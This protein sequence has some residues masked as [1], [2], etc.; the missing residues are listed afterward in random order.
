ML[1]PGVIRLKFRTP[2]RGVYEVSTMGAFRP[3]RRRL[4]GGLFA[5]LFAPNPLPS[6]ATSCPSA[7]PQAG[8]AGMTVPVATYEFDG[9]GRL[10]RVTEHRK[11]VFPHT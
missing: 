6:E 9:L 1:V 10:T 3:S 2:N 4:L 8:V 11:W 5:W 7:D